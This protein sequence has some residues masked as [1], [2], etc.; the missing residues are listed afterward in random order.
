LMIVLEAIIRASL[1][2][3]KRKKMQIIG[4]LRDRSF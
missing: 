4:T 2:R 3:L 1:S